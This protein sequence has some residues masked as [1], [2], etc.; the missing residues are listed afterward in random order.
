MK[1]KRSGILTLGL[2]I[3]IS[4]LASPA[5][6]AAPLDPTTIPKFVTQIEPLPHW[7]PTEV[8]GVDT[9]QIDVA[10]FTE[11]ILPPTFSA[12]NCTGPCLTTQFGYGGQATTHFGQPIGFIRH[13][14]SATFEATRNTPVQV[15]WINN[16]GTGHLYTVDPT[17]H[18]ADPNGIC[19]ADKTTNPPTCIM[20]S[21]PETDGMC[22]YD[23][24]AGAC[25]FMCPI[26]GC[27]VY[28]PG[29]S[30]AQAPVPIIPHL[31]GGEVQSTSDR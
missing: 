4:L 31:H 30:A 3:M 12:P 18:W 27:S 2:L 24:A 17:L 29:I 25:M 14:P 28:P 5:L 19:T 26:G 16:I 11:S 15:K 22:T 8:N 23:D 20:S 9:Y 6:G 13:A 21:V 1:E 10:E 7:L